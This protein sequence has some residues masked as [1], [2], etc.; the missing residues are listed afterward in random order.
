MA[1]IQLD[2]ATVQ[3]LR[4]IALANGASLEDYLRGLVA[5]QVVQGNEI[6]LEEFDRELDALTFSGPCLP[7]DFS[8]ADIYLDHD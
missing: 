7:A 8:R 2:D 3:G 5:H 4:A 1:S 6:S